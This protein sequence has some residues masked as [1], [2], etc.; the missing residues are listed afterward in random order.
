V[1]E[2]ATVWSCLVWICQLYDGSARFYR[3][4]PHVTWICS[5]AV[6]ERSQ[7]HPGVAFLFGC[8]GSGHPSC[9]IETAAQDHWAAVLVFSNSQQP[10]ALRPKLVSDATGERQQ[11][12]VLLSCESYIQRLC[13]T[14]SACFEQAPSFAGCTSRA[15][16][17]ACT[18]PYCCGCLVY[19]GHTG[20]RATRPMYLLL[21]CR[22]QCSGSARLQNGPCTD[23]VCLLRCTHLRLLICSTSLPAACETCRHC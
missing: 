10:W 8:C 15:L 12:R 3:H 1:A 6:H 9:H 13:F 11:A 16:R 4:A 19:T 2:F 7:M 14:L 20:V 22:I 5:A 21:A 23:G 17:F 18:Q